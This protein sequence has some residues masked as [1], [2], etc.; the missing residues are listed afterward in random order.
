LGYKSLA[1]EMMHPRL[2]FLNLEVDKVINHS[3]EHLVVS[4]QNEKELSSGDIVYALPHHVCPT[5]A[6]HEQVYVVNDHKVT[7]RW[8]VVARNRIY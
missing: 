1:S 6:L 8:E 2:Q 4:S 5:I 7:D 3:E